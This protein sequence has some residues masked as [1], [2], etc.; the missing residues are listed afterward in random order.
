MAIMNSFSS[1]NPECFRLQNPRC[2]F[3]RTLMLS[4]DN[5]NIAFTLFFHILFPY[6]L[7]PGIILSDIYR[8]KYFGHT[9]C[10]RIYLI[11]KNLFDNLTILIKL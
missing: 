3:L 7:S 11:Y 1:L 4:Y 6:L 10:V 8:N 5:N 2:P 9:F